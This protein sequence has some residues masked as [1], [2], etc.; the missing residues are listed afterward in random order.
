MK[1]GKAGL[2]PSKEDGSCIYLN[3]DNQCDIYETRPEVCN[4]KKMYKKRVKEGLKLSYK[5]YCNLNYKICNLLMDDLGIDK[6]FRINLG[7]STNA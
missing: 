5:E 7:E 4:V 6:K 1:A 3:S 2:M